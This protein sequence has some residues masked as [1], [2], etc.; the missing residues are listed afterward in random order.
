MKVIILAAA[1]SERL[2]PFTQ[3]RAKPMIR[4]AGQSILETMTQSLHTAG[5]TDIVMVVNHKSD[6][7]RSVFQH[8]H[9]LGLSIE[10]VTQDPLDGIGGAVARCREKIQDEAFLLLYGDILA[11][12]PIFERL[13]DQYMESGRAV[14]ALSLPASSQDFGNVYLDPDMKISQ[15]V[16]KPQ[17]PQ[18][19][20]YVFA[21]AFLLPSSFFDVLERSGRDME[22]SYQELIQKKALSGTIWEGEWI[23]VRQPWHILEANKILMSKWQHAVVHKS[24]RLE[25]HVEITGPV[26]IDENVTI[27]S[28]SV[29]K[30]PCYIG[31][32]CYIGNNTLI[33]SYTSLGPDST[34]G[35]GTEMKN[36]VL[37]GSSTIGRLSFIGDSVIGERVHLGTGVTTVNINPDGS[38]VVLKG[39]KEPQQTGLKKLGSFIGDDSHIGVRQVLAPGTLL[40]T[41]FEC[42]DMIT[43][44]MKE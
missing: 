1:P 32:N 22:K 10:Y 5:I 39:G 38:D 26:H 44:E 14:A 15:L 41:G 35:Y 30:G 29:L 42:E 21:G 28:G 24:V 40:G 12:G 6:S 13:M 23:D 2:L 31:K 17:N 18:L 33:R 34:V 9:H 20:N 3:N 8:G 25:G 27:G 36:A 11:T 16:E 37:L 19:S 4:V 7:I 43:L